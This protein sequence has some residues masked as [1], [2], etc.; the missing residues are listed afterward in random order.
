MYAGVPA[1]SPAAD[2][3]D[4]ANRFLDNQRVAELLFELGLADELG[5]HPNHHDRE[6]DLHLGGITKRGADF[7][8][9]GFRQLRHPR[10]H[11]G[12]ELL[13]APNGYAESMEIG[14]GDRLLAA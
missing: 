7:V 9:D 11:G 8:R 12:G 10:L 6:L 2:A 4:D 14:D 1:I 3:A 13:E 5:V